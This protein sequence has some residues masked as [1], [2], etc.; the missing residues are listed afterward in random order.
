MNVRICQIGTNETVAFASDELRR[1]LYKIDETIDVEPFYYD[2]YNPE[3]KNALWLIADPAF[4]PEALIV[5]LLP[6][7]F[8]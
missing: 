4:A 3:H 2:T 8:A 6:W 5:R 7:T 1:Y